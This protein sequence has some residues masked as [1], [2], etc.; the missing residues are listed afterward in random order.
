MTTKKI[1][2]VHC[3]YGEDDI[4]ADQNWTGVELH[5]AIDW[6]SEQ[7]LFVHLE[8]TEVVSW[9]RRNGYELVD[10]YTVTFAHDGKRWVRR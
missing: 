10:D 1:A 9:C 4:L 2:T 8:E 5:V 6:E 7:V 3:I